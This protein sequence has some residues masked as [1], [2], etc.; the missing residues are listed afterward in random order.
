[1][2]QELVI[3]LTA[4]VTTGYEWDIVDVPDP[5]VLEVA[6]SD[7]VPDQPVTVG[8]GGREEWRFVAAGRGATTMTMQYAFPGAH[9]AEV[10]RTQRFDVE[11][12]S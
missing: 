9:G 3:D 6:G 8:S 7:Y 4:N 11:V 2:G 1:V 12:R 5:N 10:A